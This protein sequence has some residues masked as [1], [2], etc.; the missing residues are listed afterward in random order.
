MQFCFCYVVVWLHASATSSFSY[1]NNQNSCEF[2]QVTAS[3]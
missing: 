2:A 1:V 3:V